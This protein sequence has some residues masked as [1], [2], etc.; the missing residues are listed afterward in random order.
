[1]IVFLVIVI[2][3]ASL[4]L[5]YPS[6]LAAVNSHLTQE[7]FSK[8]LVSLIVEVELLDSDLMNNDISLY[9][10]SVLLHYILTLMFLLC[11][12]VFAMLYIFHG[13]MKLFSPNT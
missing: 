5:A 7:T 9:L 3:P 1:M 13:W 10:D 4:L 8:S 12:A 6:C 11:K 2:L